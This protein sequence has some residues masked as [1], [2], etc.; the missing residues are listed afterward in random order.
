MAGKEFYEDAE[1]HINEVEYRVQLSIQLDKLSRTLIPWLFLYLTIWFIGLL[2]AI[3][4][5]GEEIF[6]ADASHLI[7]LAGSMIWGGI[8]GII[9]ALLPLIK[10]FSTDRDFAKSHVW[11]YIRSPLVGSGMGAV[12]F[13]FMSS[14]LLSIAGGGSFITYIL[15]GLAGYQHNVFTDLVKQLIKRLELKPKEE[16][17]EAEEKSPEGSQPQDEI[18]G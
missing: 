18:K 14:G 1:R 15:A 3:F 2:V 4:L 6:S 10:H 16:P 7:I 17:K 13:L 11:W 8:G 12:I 5:I 9:G